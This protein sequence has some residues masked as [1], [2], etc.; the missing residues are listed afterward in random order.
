MKETEKGGEY[1]M[2][3]RNEKGDITTEP[4]DTKKRMI[5]IIRQLEE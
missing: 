5:E 2:S 1:I 3:T 4:A